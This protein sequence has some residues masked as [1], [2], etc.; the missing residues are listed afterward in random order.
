MHMLEK[1]TNFNGKNGYCGVIL[2]EIS[3]QIFLKAMNKFV[4]VII[5]VK[6]L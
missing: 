1:D 6:W 2:S 5:L 3:N 4:N